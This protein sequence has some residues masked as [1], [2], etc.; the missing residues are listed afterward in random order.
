MMAET[1][2]RILSQIKNKL[3]DYGFIK[4]ENK[5]WTCT[6]DGTQDL[7][8][9]PRATRESNADG[10]IM[11]H[12]RLRHKQEYQKIRREIVDAERHWTI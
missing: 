3:R 4:F 7:S 2:Y 1:P 6:I 12:Y 5:S 10:S 8:M 9:R 11:N